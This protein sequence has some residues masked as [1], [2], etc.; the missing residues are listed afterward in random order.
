MDCTRFW[1]IVLNAAFTVGFAALVGLAALAGRWALYSKQQQ[2]LHALALRRRKGVKLRNKGMNKN[3][4]G[5]EF[6]DWKEE[7]EKWKKCLFK[8]ATKFSKV[9]A[10][11]LDT[12]DWMPHKK[13]PKVEN[14][15][16]IILLCDTT[17]TLKRLQ[18]LLEER[19]RPYFSP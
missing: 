1:E 3:L 14:K 10:E 16:Q 12:L 4:T 18:Q 19:V 9:E 11:R 17:E 13:F 6:D 2:Q 8:T 7:I 15:E 5:S